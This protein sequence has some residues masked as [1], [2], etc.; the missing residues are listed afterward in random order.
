MSKFSR[1][2]FLH[3]SSILAFN[4]PFE[5][6]IDIEQEVLKDLKKPIS[7]R[8]T[9]KG[10]GGFTKLRVPF[11]KFILFSLLGEPAQAGHRLSRPGYLHSI[12]PLL[13]EDFR[14]LRLSLSRGHAESSLVT[15]RSESS[16][17]NPIRSRIVPFVRLSWK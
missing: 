15:L 6:L 7:L 10:T 16:L 17:P 14:Q 5:L 11:L 3:R 1:R 2:E 9:I 12:S 13:S 4:K 8:D